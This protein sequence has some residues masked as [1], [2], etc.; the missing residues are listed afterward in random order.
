MMMMLSFILHQDGRRHNPTRKS[1]TDEGPLHD[2]H[3]QKEPHSY[4][5]QSGDVS[6]YG[7]PYNPYIHFTDIK[8][9]MLYIRSHIIQHIT[10][11][12][13]LC[14]Q[15][16]LYFHHYSLI[17]IFKSQTHIVFAFFRSHAYTSQVTYLYL[18]TC[19]YNRSQVMCHF[20]QIIVIDRQ[21]NYLYDII[22]LLIGL[23][24]TLFHLSR[25]LFSTLHSSCICAFNLHNFHYWSQRCIS[26][27]QTLFYFCIYQVFEDLRREF[28]M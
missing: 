15:L 3:S 5:A 23:Q 16:A 14:F 22:Y 27:S 24:F 13:Q 21:F 28:R 6:C 20:I 17:G 19:I 26:R 10:H 11:G 1:P 8:M 4:C 18:V 12:I 7:S 2:S 9:Y 25:V